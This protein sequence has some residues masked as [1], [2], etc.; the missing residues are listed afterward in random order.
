LKP[1]APHSRRRGAVGVLEDYAVRMGFNKVRVDEAGSLI[2][3][4][5]G[6]GRTL[7]MAGH[8]DTVDEP[9][10]VVLEGGRL[11]GRGGCGR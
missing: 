9:L 4:V 7:L 11:K 2:A 1:T 8:I 5:G 3:E 10:E 6:S